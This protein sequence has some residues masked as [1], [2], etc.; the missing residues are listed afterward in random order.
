MRVT[1]MISEVE[2][3]SNR[4][5]HLSASI[6]HV[7]KLVAMLRQNPDCELEARFGVLNNRMRFETG[8]SREDIDR[9]IAM[10]QTSVHVYGSTG[11]TEE[12]DFFFESADGN[13]HRTR[14]QYTSED[15]QVRPHTIKKHNYGNE[16]F[17][18]MCDDQKLGI[19][20]RVSV[21]MEEPILRMQTCVKTNLV[22]L[23]QRRRFTTTDNIWAFDF[24]MLW[25]GT[26]KTE[27]EQMQASNDPQFEIECELIDPVKALA[28]HSDARIA[29]SLL[30][31]MCDLLPSV[32]SNARIR[33]EPA[34][35]PTT[36]A[37]VTA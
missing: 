14:V 5:P 37:P 30:L 8:V 15:M 12:Q 20:I 35:L 6:P 27:A 19:D 11:W 10:M 4:Y 9:I 33:V 7:S 1:Q 22:R 24:A 17:R 23:K 16:T 25:S 32:P 26:T 2:K 3:W 18:V 21:K 36:D 13:L 34:I 28:M 29:T 31:K